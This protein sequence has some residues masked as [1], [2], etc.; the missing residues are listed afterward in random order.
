MVFGGL[1]FFNLTKK[2][3]IIMKIVKI[4]LI[5]LAFNSLVAGQSVSAATLTKEEKREIKKQVDDVINNS[6][7]R[8]KSTKIVMQ[9]GAEKGTVGEKQ[10]AAVLLTLGKQAANQTI[11][12]PKAS[13]EEKKEAR[14][15]LKEIKLFN[16]E[17][18]PTLEALKYEKESVQAGGLSTKEG[19]NFE[20]KA[21]TAEKKAE[22]IEKNLQEKGG[23]SITVTF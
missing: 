4:V 1:V 6:M 2:T 8:D 3:V 12:N 5:L 23:K 7:P 21:V 11:Q 17:S 13:R 16:P 9:I 15:T 14:K 22:R 20:R 18:K 10:G 19:Q